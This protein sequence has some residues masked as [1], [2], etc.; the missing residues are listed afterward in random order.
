MTSMPQPAGAQ[1]WLAERW[2]WTTGTE[3]AISTRRPRWA[4]CAI[5]LASLEA[6]AA[7]DA[8]TAVREMNREHDPWPAAS[9]AVVPDP[10]P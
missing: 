7:L 5:D 8:E 9:K 3:S 2:P 6:H 1:L 10:K 4:V